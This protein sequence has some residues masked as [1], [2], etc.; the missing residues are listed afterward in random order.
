MTNPQSHEAKGSP[1][2]IPDDKVVEAFGAQ[3]CPKL[4]S[5]V[6]QS[7]NT[8][9]RLNALKVLT[10]ELKNPYS[11][12]GVTRAGVVP[13]LND[14]CVNGDKDCKE[15]ATKALGALACDSNGR[16]SMIEE[17]TASAVIK[18]LSDPSPTVR[19]NL[20][21]GRASEAKRSERVVRTITRSEA[22]S[23]VTPCRFAPRGAQSIMPCRSAP[24][25]FVA[26]LLVIRSAFCYH[27]AL[28][29]NSLQ[30]RQQVRRASEFIAGP[31]RSQRSGRGWLRHPSCGKK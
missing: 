6:A 22:T 15:S 9:L 7:E 3:K 13:I 24:L 14:L 27:R 2:A 4:V 25:A 26:S 31:Q 8:K 21:V 20:Y 23:I 10:E 18:G 29:A 19:S 12:G 17:N 11:A 30:Q 16:R 28:I 5:Q 1:K